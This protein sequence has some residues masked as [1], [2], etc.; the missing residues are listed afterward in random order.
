MT[1]G[2]GLGPEVD[3]GGA[4][5]SSDQTLTFRTRRRSRLLGS[6]G[7]MRNDTRDVSRR[8][9]DA[10][11]CGSPTRRG[12]VQNASPLCLDGKIPNGYLVID[13]G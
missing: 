5:A 9:F 1:N 10:S 11:D 12:G 3:A 7:H 6:L 2:P 8:I 13:N 4:V